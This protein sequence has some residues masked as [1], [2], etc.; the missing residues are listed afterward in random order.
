MITI[1]YIFNSIHLLNFLTFWLPTSLL[2]IKYFL[3]P[4][5]YKLLEATRNVTTTLFIC[6]YLLNINFSRFFYILL[7]KSAYISIL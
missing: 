1:S 2:H 6:Q 7:L 5:F 4:T 3:G